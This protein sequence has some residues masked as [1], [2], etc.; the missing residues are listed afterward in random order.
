MNERLINN[1]SFSKICKML[2]TKK[3]VW[4]NVKP[5]LQATA[6][7]LPVLINKEF[8][9][10][11][12]L[13]E[14]LDSGLTWLDSC[15][16]IENAV[17][18]IKG[19]FSKSEED[20]LTRAE[21]AQIANA[22]LVYSAYFDTVKIFLP[23]KEG[24]LHL[25]DIQ[26]R[27]TEKSLNVYRNNLLARGNNPMESK[28]REI[29]DWELM[30]PNPLEGLDE[31]EKRLKEFYEVLNES[32]RIYL[33]G[34]S[35]V[36]DAKEH[37]RGELNRRLPKLPDAAVGIYKAQYYALAAECPDF[38]VWT[39]QNEHQQQKEIIDRGFQSLASKIDSI[40]EKIEKYAE[41]QALTALKNQ[42]T[43]Y[44]G[45]S[46]IPVQDLP[47]EDQNM[48]IPSRDKIFVPQSYKWL[49]YRK[50]LSVESTQE[51]RDGGNIGIDILNIL[52]SP[53]LGQ[54]PLVILGD[55]GAGKTML[56]HMLAGKILHQEYHVVVLHLRNLNAEL[57]IA[58]QVSQ[59]I[60]RTTDN[61]NWGWETIANAGRQK[62]ILLIFD[63]YDELLQASGKTYSNYLD[64]IVEFQDRQWNINS[65]VVR[66]IVTSRIVLIDKAD[67]P[68][69]SVILRLNP[70]DKQRIEEW[71]QVWNK[72]NEAYF[73]SKDIEVFVVEESSKAWELA[74][75]PL[76]LQML[77]LFD[78]NENALRK[79][80]DLQQVELYESLIRDFVK[81]EK[82]KDP[83]FEEK[84]PENRDKEVDKEIARIAIAALGMYNRNALH[85]TSGQLENDL[86]LL[87]SVTAG[88]ELRDSEKLLGSFFFIHHLTTQSADVEAKTQ[89]R[90]YTFLHNTFG[91]F[92]A[93]YY[94]VVQLYNLI[95]DLKRHIEK[96][97]DAPFS[98]KDWNSWYASLS[99]APL[100]RRPV[101]AQMIKDWA[102]IYFCKKQLQVNDATEVIRELLNRELPRLLRGT[103][104]TELTD[105][106]GN[107]R[108]G[109]SK[110][111]LDLMEHLAIYTNNILSIA[112]L[113]TDGVNFEAIKT[114]I[115]RAWEK[116]LHLWRYA[117][118]E[119]EIAAFA[120][121]FKIEKTGATPLL[122][123]LAN[124]EELQKENDRITKLYA[125]YRNLNDEPNRSILGTLMG[126][127]TEDIRTSLDRL[128]LRVEAKNMLLGDI[129]SGGNEKPFSSI[130]SKKAHEKLKGYPQLCL[131][132][133]DYS[134]LYGYFL[135]LNDIA[136]YS[137]GNARYVAS[138]LQDV[139]ISGIYFHCQRHHFPITIPIL[140]L[141]KKILPAMNS[142]KQ[143]RILLPFLINN[144]CTVNTQEIDGWV[145]LLL[146]SKDSIEPLIRK[147]TNNMLLDVVHRKLKRN[148]VLSCKT[149]E[150]LWHWLLEVSMEDGDRESMLPFA[151]R[152]LSEMVQNMI[153]QGNNV[154]ELIPIVTLLDDY[155]PVGCRGELYQ[156]LA[157]KLTSGNF[158]EPYTFENLEMLTDFLL[159]DLT[160]TNLN[161]W[162]VVYEHLLQC[163]RHIHCGIDT[164]S[165]ISK[166]LFLLASKAEKIGI[167]PQTICEEARETY[168]HVSRRVINL[169]LQ[170]GWKAPVLMRSFWKVTLST[171]ITMFC[172]LRSDDETIRLESEQI[173]STL[174]ELLTSEYDFSIVLR[175]HP[176]TVLAL[177]WSLHLYPKGLRKLILDK[178]ADSVE[179]ISADITH[180]QYHRL[181]ALADDF[182]HQGLRSALEQIS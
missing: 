173:T 144:L 24:N 83:K 38:F 3:S 58:E 60:A 57:S 171:C 135:F 180:Q 88:R 81:R 45:E 55:P 166:M 164:F 16:K 134:S 29:A 65:I 95:D 94:I 106:A 114:E 39:N 158:A 115:P 36:E 133:G 101:V 142:E 137:R 42:Y 165:T 163:V 130:F 4:E 170:T 154:I 127:E 160:G 92:L 110:C 31:Y 78:T 35:C 113:L 54:K 123:P 64:K 66:S 121:Q 70:F 87:S 26:Y 32:F 25:E 2:Q 155:A 146:L 85:I 21:N 67:I 132:E 51:W 149:L 19:I 20:F 14:A 182:D 148:S 143:E 124:A 27:L 119:D 6:F 157:K 44:L 147:R 15:E 63:G 84:T 52:R 5:L 98:L 17:T 109:D 145:D 61:R 12:A 128:K 138:L 125:T 76:L 37:L 7:I 69:N 56:C 102:P 50:R 105:I 11:L 77:A 107:F 97:D 34:L 118:E 93:A 116:L 131:G 172:L 10:V 33:E 13:R 53:E 1:A 156:S 74:G 169:Y 179:A 103:A 99:Y 71:C 126:A 68:R 162:L 96:Y 174:T 23:D 90:A 139:N 129:L 176:H 150:K 159:R 141:L 30:L 75:E 136:T 79:H 72:E 120:S 91:E 112:A 40:P 161:C 18:A 181:C 153:R 117:F 43:S 47:S 28:G 49:I 80:Q 89:L 22:L 73:E 108:K 122:V 82:K 59:E 168:A 86:E 8:V 46:S 111:E 41:V 100:F 175:E 48:Q 62:P 152:Q 151:W 104:I 9:T 177:C 178:L 167:T 140:K